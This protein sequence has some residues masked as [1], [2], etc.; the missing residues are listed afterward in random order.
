VHAVYTS[1]FN[2]HIYKSGL[3][4]VLRHVY[5]QLVHANVNVR[6]YIYYHASGHNV[7]AIDIEILLH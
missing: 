1:A 3:R 6:N 7:H 2:R 4:N 5:T